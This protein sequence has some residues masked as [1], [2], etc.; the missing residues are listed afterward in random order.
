MKAITG[1]QVGTVGAGRHRVAGTPGLFVLVHASGARSWIYRGWNGTKEIMR[2][3]GSVIDVSLIEAR[4]AAIRLRAGI[5]DGAELP[6]RRS[7][8]AQAAAAHT[9]QDA[10][11]RLTARKAGTVRESTVRAADS[12]WRKHMQP[13]LGAA[14]VAGTSREDVINLIA[15]IGGSSA[16][17]VRN[18]ARE[19]GSLAVSLGWMDANPAGTEIDVALPQAAKRTGTGHYRPMPHA[20]IGEWLRSLPAGPV[21]N[22]IRVLV[23]TGARLNDVLGAEWTEIDGEVLTVAGARHK[24]DLDFRIPLTAPVLEAIDA[25]RGQD[26]RYVFPSLRTAGRPLSDETVRKA[27]HSEYDL[28]GFRASFSTWAA[29]TGQDRDVTETALSH[30][31]GSAVARAYQRS[32]LFDRRRALMAAWAAYC[33]D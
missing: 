23:L 24:M 1:R 20:M 5:I 26:A 13:T 4:N 32:D 19:I 8:I 15:N 33:T 28:H 30:S 31:V 29:E 3:L 9:W 7:R 6:L 27:M 16:R 21:A 11:D 25:Q 18:L 22:A 10:F 14:D 12:V 17:K 2:G